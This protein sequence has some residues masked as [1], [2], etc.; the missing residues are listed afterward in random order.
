MG[1][2]RPVR[3]RTI[4]REGALFHHLVQGGRWLLV[5]ADTGSISYFDLEDARME[6]RVLVPDQTSIGQISMDVDI[7]PDEPILTFNIGLDIRA[8]SGWFPSFPDSQIFI[9]AIS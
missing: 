4:T 5:V 8:T 7:D 9:G 1:W 3:Q 6:E 2:S